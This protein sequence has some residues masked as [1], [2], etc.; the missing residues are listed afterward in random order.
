VVK[1]E[2]PAPQ[3]MP[4]FRDPEAGTDNPGKRG[5]RETPAPADP[6]DSQDPE[7]RPVLAEVPVCQGPKDTRACPEPLVT[8][9]SVET[10]AGQAR[11]ESEVHQGRLDRKANVARQDRRVFR[12]H[13]AYQANEDLPEDGACQ[14]PWVTA[15]PRASPVFPEIAD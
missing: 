1:A 15:V 10:R 12:V 11:M 14:E 3:E 6:Q 5:L 8:K 4:D 7:D 2:C 9:G 13:R